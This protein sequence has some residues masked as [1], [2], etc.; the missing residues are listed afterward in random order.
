[1]QISPTA[2]RSRAFTLVEILIVVV[3]LG[4]LASIVLAGWGDVTNDTSQ[5]ATYY[6][7]QKLRKAVGVYQVRNSARLP[8]VTVGDGT[9]GPLVGISGDYLMAPPINAWVGAIN[10]RK[11]VFGTGPDANYQSDYGWIFNTTT[12]D[13]WAGG[14]D[15]D[16]KPLPRN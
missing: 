10:G 7:L 5:K 1:M 6:E 11:I 8:P 3:I 4:I 15:A 13:I 2:D 9:W 12:G 14:F 16:D